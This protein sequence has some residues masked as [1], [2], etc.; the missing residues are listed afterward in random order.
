MGCGILYPRDY[1]EKLHGAAADAAASGAEAAA[2]AHGDSD[3]T[4]DSDASDNESLTALDGAAG[5]DPDLELDMFSDGSDSD[6]DE[7]LGFMQR[8]RAEPKGPKVKVIYV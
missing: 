3:G 1:H 8:H 4:R 2:A 7:F 6:E 5:V